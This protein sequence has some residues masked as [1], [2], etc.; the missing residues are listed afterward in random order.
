MHPPLDRPHPECQQQINDLQTCHATTSKLKF[1]GCNEVKF[2]L[3][4]CLKEEKQNLLKVLNKDIEQKRQMEE[5]AY[6]QAL[7]K[8]ISFEEYLKQDKDY[9]RA[10][11]EK[12]NK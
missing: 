6:Q 3:D 5:N 11:N 4:R 12:N 7:G 2:A 9:I 10:T 1:W 8:D